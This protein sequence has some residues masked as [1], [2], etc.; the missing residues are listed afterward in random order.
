LTEAEAQAMHDDPDTLFKAFGDGA[1]V[2]RPEFDA[3]RAR[4]EEL[5]PGWPK[6]LSGARRGDWR[7][8][9]PDTPTMAEFVVSTA[10]RVNQAPGGSRERRLLG[11]AQLVPLPYA[12][13]EFFRDRIGSRDNV[14]R[15]C[16]L[17]CLVLMDEFTLLH[18]TLR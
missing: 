14:R 18:P 16:E 1:V 11:T 13:D 3:L 10:K 9:G 6:G 12:F 8:F 7:P 5:S 2:R 17:G 4:V 15:L